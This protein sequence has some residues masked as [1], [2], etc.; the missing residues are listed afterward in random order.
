MTRFLVSIVAALV[1]S[2]CAHERGL[3]DNRSIGSIQIDT[4]ATETAITSIMTAQSEAWNRGDIPGFMEYY[5][6]SDQ[7]RFG[8]GGNI[9]RGWQATLDRY[10]RTYSS[11]ERM[12]HL[13][14]SDLEII[15]LASDAAIVHGRWKLT[16]DADTPSGLFTLVFRNLGSGWVIVSDTT[17]SASAG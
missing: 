8:S 17:T 7:L 13:D 12:G 2:A 1:L 10:L 14:F 5:W 9:T 3:T 6:K 11:R 16:R 15:A 4:E